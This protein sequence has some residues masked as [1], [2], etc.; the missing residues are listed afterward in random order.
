MKEGTEKFHIPESPEPAEQREL[1]KQEIQPS[2]ER[3]GLFAEA[4]EQVRS[5]ERGIK[6]ITL[7]EQGYLPTQKELGSID[8]QRSLAELRK[9][10][11]TVEDIQNDL[12]QT[13][14]EQIGVAYQ[15]GWTKEQLEGAVRE[16]QLQYKREAVQG[17]VNALRPVYENFGAVHSEENKARIMENLTIT[18]EKTDPRNISLSQQEYVRKNV[19][20][21][22]N[23]ELN[24]EEA[25]RILQTQEAFFNAW[26]Q[27][28][29]DWRPDSE[30]ENAIKRIKENSGLS[31]EEIREEMREKLKIPEK[32]EPT[33]RFE[34]R[35]ERKEIE[36]LGMPIDVYVADKRLQI[37]D[38]R[39]DPRW[40]ADYLLIDP[41]KFDQMN[42]TTG[43]KGV[44]ENE[45]FVLGRQNPLRFKLPDTVSRTHLKVELRNG[46]LCLEDLGS[47]NGTVIELERPKRM[48]KEEIESREVAP[49]KERAIAEF[50]AYVKKHQPEIERELQQG[51]DLGE[52]FYHDFYN[53]NIDELKYRE[54]D[55]VVQQLKK[56]YAESV[57]AVQEKLLQEGESGR[58]LVPMDNGYWLYCNV[59]GGFRNKEGLGRFYLNLKPEHVGRFFAEAN[60][61]FL[62]AGLHSQ[63]KIPLFGDADTFN[64]LDKMVIY[65]DAE[66]EQK[67]FQILENLYH[68]NREVFDETGTP[69]F[70][71]DVKNSRS[72]SMAGIGFAEEPPFRNE[73]FGTI[74]ARILAEV[75]LDAKYSYFSISDP[76]FDFES[77][78]HRACTKY[79]VDPMNPA[80]N[81]SR[82]PAKFMELRRRMKAKAKA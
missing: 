37:I 56:E 74:R 22:A 21:A 60:E 67:T 77:S 50:Q 29:P 14:D 57:K 32:E 8:V 35:G 24:T 73:S 43:Y 19:L 4:V 72:V 66:E 18:I 25:R 15:K 3:R 1:E 41:A 5:N 33:E 81:L 82:G 34:L 51:R 79:E 9:K 27:T 69:R 36:Y 71:A 53:K 46:K 2:P 31:L 17:V 10:Y 80:F 55:L 16:K 54:G 52:L 26:R 65:F 68:S 44:R 28:S 40:N 76:Q 20:A 48:S 75:Y 13:V 78:F 63:M 62:D 47:T 11:P 59:N 6:L 7:M 38:V 39:E 49:E 61:Q 45:P 42:P 23:Q 30:L 58:D 12:A 64:R 70:T